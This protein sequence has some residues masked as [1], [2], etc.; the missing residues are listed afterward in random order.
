MT[1]LDEKSKISDLKIQEVRTHQEIRA[2]Y[3]VMHQLR[4]SL[5]LDAFL[6]RVV[7]VQR[8]GYR[9]F[10]A[11]VGERI[12][13]AIGLRILDDLCWGHN[14]YVDD[15]VVDES[16][17]RRAIGTALMRFAEN[18]AHSHECQY[19]RLASGMSRTQAHEFYERLGYCKTSFMFA[20]QM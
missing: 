6:V 9:L 5:D 8:G 2:V 11:C 4:D 7:Q 10:Y 19:V 20:L 3:P 18:L 1:V 17:R 15:L 14:L 13:G 12:V 16:L